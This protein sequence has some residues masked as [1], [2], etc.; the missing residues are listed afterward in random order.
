MS[1]FYLRTKER[2]VFEILEQLPYF[3]I[4]SFLAS[5]DFYLLQIT[6]E[7]SSDPD[8]DSQNIIP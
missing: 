5:L 6:F 4:N 7:N 2:Y 1:S 8:Q 3:A